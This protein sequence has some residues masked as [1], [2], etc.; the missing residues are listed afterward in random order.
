MKRV[1]IISAIFFL[2]L[3]AF[4]IREALGLP[5]FESFGPGGDFA[6][7][8]LGVLLA[9]LA[10]LLVTSALRNPVKP[11]AE[12]RMPPRTG[13]IRI[14]SMVAALSAYAFVVEPVGYLISTF[15]FL[16][17]LLFMLAHLSRRWTVAAGAG[18]ALLFT[19]LF[20]WLLGIPLPHG[21]LPL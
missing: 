16:V 2:L 5:K 4:A 15:L 9:F 11:E 12:P 14:V 1:D 20:S 13:L 3:S 17:F 18:G 7:F 6:P 8:W 10:I 21:I 19:A